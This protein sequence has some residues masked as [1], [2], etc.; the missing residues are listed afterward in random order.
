ME[1]ALKTFK[2]GPKLLARMS[3]A[4]LEILLATEETKQLAGSTL[5]TNSVRLHT[6]YMGTRRTKVT[7]LRVPVEINGDSLGA[8][9]LARYKQVVDVTTTMSKSGIATGDFILQV[10]LKR[11]SFGEI[12]NVL[13]CRKK[14]VL[15]IVEGRRPYCWSCDASGH[16]S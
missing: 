12:P 11:K 14:M 9:F 2:I 8:F 13:M 16:M 10:I 1:E 4:L 15:V 6:E 3:N 7:V 5:A